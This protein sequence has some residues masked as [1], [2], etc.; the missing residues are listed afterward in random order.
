MIVTEAQY[1]DRGFVALD[2]PDVGAGPIEI[3]V[4]GMADRDGH[5]F[6][7]P[8]LEPSAHA[9]IPGPIAEVA[10]S[11]SIRRPRIPG[12]PWSIL[13]RTDPPRAPLPPLVLVGHPRTV[14]LNAQD[15]EILE[16]LPSCRGGDQ[17]RIR[18][19]L[20]APEVR[21]RLFLDPS[22]PPDQISPIRL[23]H[24]EVEAARL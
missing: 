12:R 17:F 22:T 3:V 7:S 6:Y 11:Y 5:L 16:H 2:L 10:V 20:S 8:G 21:L 18:P 19:K 1:S 14:P 15:G 23:K 4:F 24:P 13:L 9:R